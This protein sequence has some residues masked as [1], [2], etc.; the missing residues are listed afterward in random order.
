[1]TNLSHYKD[2]AVGDC[3]NS[4]GAFF[5]AKGLRHGDVIDLVFLKEEE[6]AEGPQS[7]K[8]AKFLLISGFDTEDAHKACI[9]YT[10]SYIVVHVKM[11]PYLADY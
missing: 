10:T 2:Y 4:G 9:Q 7:Q 8:I 11:S 6:E 5:W 3:Y 1:M